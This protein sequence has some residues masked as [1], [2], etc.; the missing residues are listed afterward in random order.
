MRH[1]VVE[2]L[3]DA[4]YRGREVTDDELDALDL[5][6]HDRDLVK[7]AAREAAFIWDGGDREKARWHARERAAEII[8]VLPE[9][10]RDPTYL[11]D[12]NEG[13]DHLGPAELAARVRR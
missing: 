8:G 12:P 3:A 11:N 4:S 2:V 9:E 6:A 13:T 1:P 10:Q 7:K 5:A